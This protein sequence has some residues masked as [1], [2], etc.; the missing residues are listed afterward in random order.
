MKQSA[1]KQST[2]IVEIYLDYSV[3]VKW[4]VCVYPVHCVKILQLR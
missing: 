4:Y 2:A 1:Q 3:A